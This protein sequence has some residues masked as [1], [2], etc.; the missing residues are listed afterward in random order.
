MNDSAN[1]PEEQPTGK[2][3]EPAWKEAKERVAARNERARK[4]GRARRDAYE[5]EKAEARQMRERRRMAALLEKRG[6]P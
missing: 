1:Q 2:R 4:E 5:T 6:K 3:G